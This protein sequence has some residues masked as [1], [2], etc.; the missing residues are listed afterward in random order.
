MTADT[1]SEIVPG[2]PWALIAVMGV[3]GAGK[4]TFIQTVSKATDVVIGHNLES[5]KYSNLEFNVP[6]RDGLT[7]FHQ[8]T[9]EMKGYTFHY[10]GYNINLIDTPGF[11]DTHKSETQVLQDIAN[12][13]QDSYEQKQKLHGVIYLHNINNVRMEGSALRNLRMFRQL[14]GEEPLKNVILATSFWGKVEEKTGTDREAE[15]RDRPEFWGQMLKRGSRMMRYTG[16]ASALKI[17]SHFL[18]MSPVPLEIQRELVEEAKPLIETAAGKSVNEELIRLEK[19]HKEEL[20]KLR[21][22]YQLAI[23]EKDKELQETLAEHQRKHD[24]DLD[25]VFRQQEQL[26]AERRAEDRRRQNDLEMHLKRLEDLSMESNVDWEKHSSEL[27]EMSFDELVSKIRANEIK[28]KADDRDK[29][30]KIIEEV[31]KSSELSSSSRRK[32]K[33]T[34]KF[35]LSALLKVV[36]PVTSLC[37]L[38]VPISFPFDFGQDSNN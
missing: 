21:E 37:L 5:C 31:K 15:L 24:R 26:R 17:V 33:G 14:C 2:A 18:D 3:T 16:R 6:V 25:R 22:D 8:G 7:L 20:K 1:I 13:L 34:A 36:V 29:V 19:W 9:S 4:S 28:V 35:L 11:N 10:Y 12:W 32:M 38:G 30:E 23:E 27:Q